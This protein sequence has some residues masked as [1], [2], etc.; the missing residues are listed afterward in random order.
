MHWD[1]GAKRERVPNVLTALLPDGTGVS[2]T[3]KSGH[4]ET[5]RLKVNLGLIVIAAEVA[6][7]SSHD[8]GHDCR[9]GSSVGNLNDCGKQLPYRPSQG[10]SDGLC[11]PT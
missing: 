3:R 8:L 7:A 11:L 5:T 10:R 1:M 4:L 2:P 9:H 6:I